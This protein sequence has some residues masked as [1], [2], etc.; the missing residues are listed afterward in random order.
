MG[1]KSTRKDLY[2]KNLLFAQCSKDH[3]TVEV[4]KTGRLNL[5]AI[6]I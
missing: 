5:S 3:N 1:G 4:V 6:F 2:L